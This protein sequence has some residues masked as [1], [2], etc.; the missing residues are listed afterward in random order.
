MKS[1]ELKVKHEEVNLKH[2]LAGQAPLHADRLN[3][4]SD[5]ELDAAEAEFDRIMAE[6]KQ[7]ARRIP[8]WPWAAAAVAAVLVSAV[9][10][11]PETRPLSSSEQPVL[12][13]QTSHT[14][15]HK[16]V[17]PS[18]AIE[19]SEAISKPFVAETRPKP[20]SRKERQQSGSSQQL[21]PVPTYQPAAPS[22]PISYEYEP[23]GL[24]PTAQTDPITHSDRVAPQDSLPPLPQDRQ[25]L[26]DIYLAEVALQVAYKQR[27]VQEAVSAYQTSIITGEEPAQ[28]I[29]AF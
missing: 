2:Y 15:A 6:R 10:L 24:P 9:L 12:I 4:P 13:S 20:S 7:L 16:P 8:L 18:T 3:L 26:A 5:E 23:S 17:P 29:I 22:Q 14:T 1:E 11:W 25:A 28:P 21:S 19:D 27:A